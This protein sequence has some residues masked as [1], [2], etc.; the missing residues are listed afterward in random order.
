MNKWIYLL[1]VALLSLLFLLAIHPKREKIAFHY[2]PLP[3]QIYID[4]T[5]SMRRHKKPILSQVEKL[6]HPRA[7]MEFYTLSEL[8]RPVKQEDLKTIPFNRFDSYSL[9]LYEKINTL[10]SNTMAVVVS[11][12]NFSDGNPFV[13]EKRVIQIN[14]ALYEEAYGVEIHLSHTDHLV[15]SGQTHRI[16]VRIY[17][18]V[19]RRPLSLSYRIRHLTAEE[20]IANEE[21]PVPPG[22]IVDIQVPFSARSRWTLLASL[23]AY[24]RRE[25]PR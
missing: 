21:L 12:F 9:D 1:Y 19:A 25:A 23:P 11:D 22:E 18:R 15:K 2:T 8:F 10:P 20:E 6:R 24:G 7:R 16:P 4:D 5:Y 3:V 13:Q 17:D 14:T